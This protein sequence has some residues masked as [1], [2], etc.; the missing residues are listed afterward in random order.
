MNLQGI[1]APYIAVVNPM[2]PVSVRRSTGS[3]IDAAGNPTPQYAAPVTILAQIQA[4]SGR[5]LRQLDGLN[6]NGT[7]K[8]IY[9]NG[10]LD[11][12]ERTSLKG[13]DLVTLPDSTVWLVTV[14][15]EPWNLTA[16]W[17]KAV[18]TEQNDFPSP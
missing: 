1:I 2:V 7:L 5:D 17:T 4:L 9:V 6:L 16:G 10:T 12:T 15:P 13:G 14:V 11:G 18:I 8:T 3:T